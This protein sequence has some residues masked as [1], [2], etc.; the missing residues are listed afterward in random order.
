MKFIYESHVSIN[1]HA[2]GFAA[3][4]MYAVWPTSQLEKMK[5]TID[6]INQRQRVGE[7][8]QEG[9]KV[10]KQ[11]GHKTHKAN[12]VQFGVNCTGCVAEIQIQNASLTNV[13]LKSLS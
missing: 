4:R 5:C 9:E 10:N 8:A 13:P 6:S 1:L 11:L 3:A 7:R 2:T 12:F